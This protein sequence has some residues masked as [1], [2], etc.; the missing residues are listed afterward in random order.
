MKWTKET[1]RL[2]EGHGWTAKPGHLILALDRGA[3]VLEFPEGWFMEP[4]AGQID[5]RDAATRAD[6]TCV[7]AV[8]C[9][10]LPVEGAE[11]PLATLV[12]EAAQADD[13]D[14][15][16]IGPM[17]ETVRDGLTIAWT[18]LRVVDPGEHRESRWRICLARRD[19]HQC[20][21]TLD[22]WPEDEA[23]LSA[24]WDEVLGSLRLGVEVDD[25]T[26]GERID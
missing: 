1:Y 21:I 6:S 23:R 26:R 17:H 25:P 9:L 3:V 10:V 7:L 8:S 11:L 13:R 15:I 24:I 2:R 16:A 19:R 22:Y 5:I 20:L 18:E 12:I 14:R 4:S